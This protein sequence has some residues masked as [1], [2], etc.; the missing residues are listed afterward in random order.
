MTCFFLLPSLADGARNTFLT[1]RL[2][3]KLDNRSNASSE[4][5]YAGAHAIQIGKKGRG[6][7]R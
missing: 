1:Q 5:D 3:D 6:I 7:P 2:K 4:I